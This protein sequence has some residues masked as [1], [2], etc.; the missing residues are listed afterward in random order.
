MFGSKKKTPRWADRVADVTNHFDVASS[1][2]MNASFNAEWSAAA[3]TLI[4]EM[5]RIIDVEIERR[6]KDTKLRHVLQNSTY[7][8]VAN[9][10][11]EVDTDVQTIAGR[12]GRLVE[13]GQT[14]V[15]YRSRAN[16]AYYLRPP[17][18]FTGD[19]FLE[20]STA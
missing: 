12:K 17:E 20:E 8:L 6:G 14:L 5:A 16:G 13:S 2:G 11:F 15:I 3:S 7:D 19:R 1:F 18:E 4:K 9:G 10:T